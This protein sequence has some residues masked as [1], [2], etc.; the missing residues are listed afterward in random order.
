MDFEMLKLVIIN[1]DICL[2]SVNAK[3]CNWPFSIGNGNS[4]E[5][6]FL[7]IKNDFDLTIK[8]SE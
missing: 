2:L 1:F 8:P 4:N 3:V 7:F 5:K 6:V